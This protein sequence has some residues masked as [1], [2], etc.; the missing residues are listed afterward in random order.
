M[1]NQNECITIP[2]LEPSEAWY[3]GSQISTWWQQYSGGLTYTG[4]SSRLGP[5]YGKRKL[6]SD[7]KVEFSL[8]QIL[9][10][11]L[12]YPLMATNFTKEQCHNI[13]LKPVL[14]STLPTMGINQ[15]FPQ[16]VAH[17]PQSCQG[18]DIPNLFTEQLIAHIVTLLWFGSPTGH[19]LHVNVDAFWL[20][21]GLS[22]PI[23]QM[24]LDIFPYMTNL[25][26]TQTWHQCQLLQIEITMDTTN[27]G[28]MTQTLWQGN[29]A[30]PHSTWSRR[31]QSSEHEPLQNVSSG[32]LSIWHLHWRWE[33]DQPTVLGQKREV[34]HRC[35]VGHKWNAP[36]KPNGIYGANTW[37]KHCHSED[38]T[39]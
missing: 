30:H 18:L 26:L 32:D 38:G 33:G 15:H 12:A 28:W 1:I 29:Y 31:A 37:M 5:A 16:A 2:C 10:P 4:C 11:K 20:E 8:Q 3:I 9:M 35:T 23:F 21:A 22:G 34:S 39:V 6:E 27:F 14:A 13:L 19:L 25:W 36:H 7:G 24:P 17:G